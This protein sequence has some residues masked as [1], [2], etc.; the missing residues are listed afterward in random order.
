MMQDAGAVRNDLDARVIAHI[1]DILAYG[2]VGMGDL[3]PQR[4]IPPI[5]EIIEGIALIMDSALRPEK[6]ADSSEIGK[7]IVRQLADAGRLQYEQ[8]KDTE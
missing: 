4:D 2:L 3:L 5:D 6:S 7:A 8:M 1:M